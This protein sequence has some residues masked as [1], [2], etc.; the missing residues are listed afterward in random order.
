MTNTL[1]THNKKNTITSSKRFDVLDAFRGI[2]ASLIVF[3]HLHII[4]SFT[5][6][7]VIKGTWIFVEFFFVLSGFVLAHSYGFRKNF[8]F[9]SAIKSR[10]FRIYPLHIFMLGVILLIELFKMIAN[11]SFNLNFPSQ[12]FSGSTALKELFYNVSLLQ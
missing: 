12:A 10:F 7:T 4:N 6:T 9:L 5:E 1:L 11:D 3:F 2:T 8:H